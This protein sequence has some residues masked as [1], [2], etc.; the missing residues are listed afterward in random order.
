MPFAPATSYRGDQYL[1]EGISGAGRAL[2]SGIEAA[3]DRYR[4]IQDAGKSADSFY[5]ALGDQAQGALGIHP[6]EW[7]TLG[8]REKA[9]AMVG[10]VKAQ[11]VKEAIARYNDLLQQQSDRK[12][13]ADVVQTWMNL[14][15][16]RMIAAALTNGPTREG[17]TILDRVNSGDVPAPTSS[18]YFEAVRR[19]PGAGRSPLVVKSLLNYGG[20][21][22]KAKDAFFKPTDQPQSFG[23]WKR[24]PLGPNNS[25]LVYEDPKMGLLT[26]L[27]DDQGHLRGWSVVDP[28]GRSIVKDYKGDP[29]MKQATDAEGNPLQGWYVDATG[30]SHDMRSLME[31]AMGES[32]APAGGDAALD[33]ELKLAKD[34]LAAGAPREKVA[35]KF[36][37]RTG[38]DLPQ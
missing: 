34:A 19:T 27:H 6:E 37:A 18:D 4:Q 2:G 36:K 10:Y 31:K 21:T 5:N 7:K 29:T 17:A 3:V 9:N 24:I 25:Q 16:Q 1:F 11:G 14:P 20:I 30:K 23:S 8:A 38:K 28:K 32:P 33:Q 22:G 13:E 12:A 15:R 26:P 35:A